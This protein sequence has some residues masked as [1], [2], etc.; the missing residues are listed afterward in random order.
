M[1]FYSLLLLCLFGAFSAFGQSIYRCSY[2]SFNA[3]TGEPQMHEAFIVRFDDGTGFV[4]VHFKDSKGNQDAVV[5]MDL[6]EALETFKAQSRNERD[7]T[8][9]LLQG[10]NPQMVR[11]NMQEKYALDAFGFFEDEEGFFVPW[12]VFRGDL[13]HDEDDQIQV[14]EYEGASL[15]TEEDLTEELVSQF[16]NKDE[17]FYTSLFN[18]SVRPLRPD[19]LG[20]TLHLL[21]VAD[22]QDEEIGPTCEKDRVRVTKNYRELAQFMGIGFKETAVFGPSYN[23][24]N[25]EAAIQALRPSPKDIVVFYYTGHGF[26]N[27]QDQ[28]QFPHL[29]LRQAS[30]EPLKENSLNMEIIYS[31]IKA[32]GARVNLVMSDCCNSDP[33]AIAPT[34]ADVTRTR[35]SGVPW[36]KNT[37]QALFMPAK[38]VSILMTAASKGELAAGNMAYGGFFSYNFKAALDRSLS[39]FNAMRGVTWD[40]IIKDA[41]KQTILKANNTICDIPTVGQKPCV[42]HPIFRIN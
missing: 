37:C 28:H 12:K 10:E 39:P 40:Q 6:T 7:T 18:V 22:T 15:I 35:N 29:V 23:K 9:M 42:Q 11:G 24:K 1:R 20:T 26:S 25:V 17:E 5:D 21:V 16:F 36:D 14:L 33:S 41:Q 13:I 32:K 4:R 34:M 30:F 8:Y 38:P 31:M 3:A 2:E 27:P 19:Q